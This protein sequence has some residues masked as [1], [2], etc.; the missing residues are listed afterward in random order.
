MDRVISELE[1]SWQSALVHRGSLEFYAQIGFVVAGLLAA[2]ILMLGFKARVRI[3]REEPV[4]GLLLD[5]R[6]ALHNAG[7]LVFPVLTTLLRG[8]AT[9][10]A[11]SGRIAL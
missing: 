1:S 10:V 5:L 9:P 3:F 7:D 11:A 4:S 2:W 6:T 8:F